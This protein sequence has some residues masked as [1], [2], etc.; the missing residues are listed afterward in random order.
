[1]DGEGVISEHVAQQ[2]FQCFNTGKGNTKDLPHS[3]RPKLWD[4][5]NTRL[6]LTKSWQHVFLLKTESLTGMLR[7]TVK[8]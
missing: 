6:L 3:G 2:W 7:H 8:T 5:G 4:I 1:M